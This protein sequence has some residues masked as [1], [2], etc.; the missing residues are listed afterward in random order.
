MFARIDDLP[1]GAIGFEAVG[2]ITEA[3]RLAVLEPTIE[4]VLEHGRPVRLLYLAGP[5]FDGYDPDTLLDDAVF[6][7]RHF[8]DFHKIAF[9]AEE[10]PYRRAVVALEGLMPAELRLFPAGAVDAAKAWLAE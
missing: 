3:D 1:I 8:S 4:A 5:R 9:L 6:G 7:S 2:R 10:G